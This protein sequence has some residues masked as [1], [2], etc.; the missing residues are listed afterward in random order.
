MALYM[1][2]F[3][4]SAD[5][6]DTHT[7]THTHTHTQTSIKHLKKGLKLAISF[8]VGNAPLTPFQN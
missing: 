4:H 5:K 1:V 3:Q 8:T 6:L 2:L 7:H